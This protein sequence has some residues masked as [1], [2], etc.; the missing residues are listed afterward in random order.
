MTRTLHGIRFFRKN[1]TVTTHKNNDAHYLVINYIET[2]TTECRRQDAHS[3]MVGHC[4][5][6]TDQT[7]NAQFSVVAHG[8]TFASLVTLAL[9]Q[10]S[11]Q[12]ANPRPT[13]PK[14]GRMLSL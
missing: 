6:K 5:R 9:L 11:A 10:A 12:E 3:R 14:F 1:N 4:D 7:K 13:G 8:D 2:A